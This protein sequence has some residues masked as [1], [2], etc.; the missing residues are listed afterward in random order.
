MVFVNAVK[1]FLTTSPKF[2]DAETAKRSA[3]ISK[4]SPKKASK[5]VEIRLQ[6]PPS[7]PQ[8]FSS[9]TEPFGYH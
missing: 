8:V 7:F 2:K 9:Q 4:E 5:P 1:L 6:K 3:L